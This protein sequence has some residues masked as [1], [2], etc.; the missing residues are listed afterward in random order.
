MPQEHQA[1]AT[2]EVD[3]M[4][5]DKV[6]AEEE[7][8]EEEEVEQEEMITIRAADYRA[9]QQTLADIRFDPVDQQRD[10]C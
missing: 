1:R 4:D 7:E 9:M 10:A 8:A 5:M 3:L 2:D 6:A